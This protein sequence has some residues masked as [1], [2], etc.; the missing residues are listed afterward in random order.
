LQ[1]TDV[2]PQLFVFIFNKLFMFLVEATFF[3]A[4][5]LSFKKQLFGVH[6]FL[7]KTTEP[8]DIAC[9]SVAATFDLF[10]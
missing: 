10:Y 3:E 2:Y 7:H 8:T 6:E 5:S 1:L 4:I 9:L